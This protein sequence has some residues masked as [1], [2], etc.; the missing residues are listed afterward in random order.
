MSH[1]NGFVCVNCGWGSL[2][3]SNFRGTPGGRFLCRRDDCE[4]RARRADWVD[5]ERW[6]EWP[7][8]KKEKT[9]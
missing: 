4:Q 1:R 9:T 8:T 6:I 3:R 5:D 2:V 7:E